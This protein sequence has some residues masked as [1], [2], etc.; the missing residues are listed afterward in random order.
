VV[1]APGGRSSP[2]LLAVL[3]SSCLQGR[4][5]EVLVRLRGTNVAYTNVPLPG[6]LAARC[7]TAPRIPAVAGGLRLPVLLLMRRE[8]PLL[9]RPQLLAPLV[10]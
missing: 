5:D 2:L 3:L 9:L 6:L 1:V 8:R 4:A 10:Q 7:P